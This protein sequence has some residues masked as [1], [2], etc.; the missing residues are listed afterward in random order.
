M[1]IIAG[2]TA[3]RSVRRRWANFAFGMVFVGTGTRINSTVFVFYFW[4]FKI[5]VILRYIEVVKMLDAHPIAFDFL[6]M[7]SDLGIQGICFMLPL[8]KAFLVSTIVHL[9]N[10][11]LKSEKISMA[12]L[13]R[14]TQILSLLISVNYS[15]EFILKWH[16]FQA[17]FFPDLLMIFHKILSNS[18]NHEAFVLMRDLWEFLRV[19]TNLSE[20]WYSIIKFA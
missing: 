17:D 16:F 5:K 9:E 2:S 13:E 8:V 7:L 18:N 15:P 19:R 12:N 11:S 6:L 3:G 4:L 1:D 14:S 10:T 20:S